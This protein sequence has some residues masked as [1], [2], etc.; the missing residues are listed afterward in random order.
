MTK[1][2]APKL[3]LAG[4]EVFLPNALEKAAAQR[5]LCEK[6]GFLGLHPLDN[7]IDTMH[8]D[9][10]KIRE[11]YQAIKLYR[12]DIKKLLACFGH[13]AILI[14]IQIYLGDI[15]QITLCDI[16]VANCNAF[17]GALIDDG[18]AY[19]L[20][21]GNAL[22]KPSYGYIDTMIPAVQNIRNRYPC[23]T[24]PAGI[25]ID[26]D[27]YLVVDDFGTAINLMMQCGMM[28]SGGRLIEGNFERCLQAIRADLDAGV[29]QLPT[30]E[31]D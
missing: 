15:Q 24:G 9:V 7:N 20:G 18:T 17:R 8:P 21:F 29:L 23:T 22:G 6:Y 16:V 25:P 30:R 5:A 28:L 4:P 13:D 14:A 10:A 12:G 2:R 11:L 3:Y 1:S 19:E 27:G 26:Q 31:K